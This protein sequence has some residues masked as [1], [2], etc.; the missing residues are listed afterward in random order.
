M[1]EF[2]YEFI[3]FFREHTT[4]LSEIEVDIIHIFKFYLLLFL[5][6]RG[7]ALVVKELKEVLSL[8]VHLL[9][10]GRHLVF[11]CEGRCLHSVLQVD[12]VEEH[13]SKHYEQGSKVY[14]KEGID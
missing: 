4:F 1:I 5:I 10:L 7:T 14:V 9:L 11:L 2:E 6:E 13:E 8:L 12:S 3:V